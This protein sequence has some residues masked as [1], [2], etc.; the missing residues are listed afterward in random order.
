MYF[1]KRRLSFSLLLCRVLEDA[2]SL[3]LETCSEGFRH[4]VQMLMLTVK[5]LAGKLCEMPHYCS[6]ENVQEC[7][8]EL[9]FTV[10]RVGM[11]TSTQQVCRSVTYSSL[12]FLLDQSCI[13]VLL[14]Q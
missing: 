9:L 6:V 7:V 8:L 4:Q 2:D 3:D 11:E 5:R 14:S 10:Q 13:P 1:V 12:S